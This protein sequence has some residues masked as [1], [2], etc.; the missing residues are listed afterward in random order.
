MVWSYGIFNRNH[1]DHRLIYVFNEVVFLNFV[2]KRK[3]KYLYLLMVHM[4][5]TSVKYFFHDGY[6]GKI[7]LLNQY[8][9][10]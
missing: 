8:K 6:F 9:Y 4:L 2:Y 3:K 10:Q 7:M 5:I 1:L